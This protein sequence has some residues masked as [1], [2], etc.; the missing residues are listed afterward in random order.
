MGR[1]L[2]RKGKERSAT[3]NMMTGVTVQRLVVILQDGCAG[4]AKGGEAGSATGARSKS[5]EHAGGGGG[6]IRGENGPRP[7]QLA[8]LQE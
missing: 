3:G 1:K 4:E 8:R 5:A 2:G 6:A 7:G